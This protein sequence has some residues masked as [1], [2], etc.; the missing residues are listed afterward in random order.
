MWNRNERPTDIG[1]LSRRRLLSLLG[2]GGIG[3]T[4]TSC[5]DT[6][7]TGTGSTGTG[8]TAGGGKPDQPMTIPEPVVD[9][10][11]D[12][13]RLRWMDSGDMKARFF[14][15][16]FP[17]YEKKH[18]N[19]DVEYEGT[20]WNQIT[21]VITLGVRN[22]T[23]PD[24]FQLPS[25]ITMGMAVSNDWVGAYEDIVPN[26]DEIKARFPVGSFSPGINIFDG[27]TYSMPFT[28]SGRINN[29]LL[30]NKDLVKDLDVD[31][32]N[33]V[34][35][36]DQLREV[37][38]QTTKQG[39]GSYYGIVFGL[40]QPGGL[41]GPVGAMAEMAGVHGG[42]D[43]G[44][45]TVG[46][47]WR[48]GRFNV[49]NPEVVEAIE[50]MLAIK[51]DGSAHPDSVS[52]DAPGA[53]ERMPQGQAALMIQGPWNIV[54]WQEENP[55]FD[56]G[57]GLTPQKDPAEIWPVTYGPGGSNAW[58]YSSKTELGPVIADIV[59]YM[60]TTDGQIQWGQY[61]GASD[62]PML[63]EAVEQAELDPLQQKALEYGKEYAVLRPEPAARNPDVAEVYKNLV[64]ATPTFSDVL[65][66]LY[67]GEI[68]DSVEKAMA[69]LDDRLEQA[70]EDAIAKARS[71]GAKVDRDDW[72]FPDWNPREPYTSI[73]RK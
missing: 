32:D 55:A 30:Y 25:Q 34:I 46:I 20:N 1:S 47:D 62:P 68:E 13:V 66:G 7:G 28:G 72:V 14:D 6:S 39:G 15:A 31:L 61:V 48:T 37:C 60:T 22:G 12:D 21:Q 36:W 67:T 40:A 19:I 4:M 63:Q 51:S 59:N 56:L 2:V 73:Y 16:F 65:V 38:K 44:S 24:V 5:V 69:K 17:A 29:L 53:R 54:P 64:P 71:R 49:T 26:L 42:G 45:G 10:P 23:A 41:S 50:L 3:L 70:L 35:S 43:S 52:L 27:K 11:A 33:E 8:G 58:V 18:P 9:L 57:V